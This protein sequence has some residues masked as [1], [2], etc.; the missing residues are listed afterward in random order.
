MDIRRKAVERLTGVRLDGLS[1]YTID[2]ESVSK[3]NIENM[4]GAVQV[5]VGVAGPLA[6]NGQ[7]ADG[8]FYVPLATT[9]G[10]LVASVSR[11]CKAIT[12]AGGAIVRVVGD[13]MTRAPVFKV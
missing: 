8:Q 6:V 4:I 10:A 5:P 9:E 1:E 13:E 7:F 2:A 12:A 3:R 11:G